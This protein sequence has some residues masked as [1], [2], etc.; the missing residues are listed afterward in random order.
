MSQYGTGP[1]IRYRAL[2]P[3]SWRNGGGTTREIATQEIDDGKGYAWRLSL[4]VINEAGSFSEFPDMERVFTVVMG[5]PVTLTV[6]GRL[7]DVERGA[8]FRFPG[9]AAVQAELPNGPVHALN[10]IARHTVVSASVVVEQLRRSR[11]RPVLFGQCA[12]LLAG[13]VTLA[14]DGAEHALGVHDTVRCRGRTAAELTGEGLV[15]V[16]SFRPAHR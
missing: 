1:I 2:R 3:T 13:R 7:H 15:A 8:P 16:V 12:I 10:V 6:D 4:A 14:V 5:G 11:P 9:D